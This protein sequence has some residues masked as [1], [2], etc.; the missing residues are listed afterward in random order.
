MEVKEEEEG[1]EAQDKQQE[2]KEQIFRRD[3]RKDGAPPASAALVLAACLSDWRAG[4][5]GLADF[6]GRDICS[7]GFA[8]LIRLFITLCDMIRLSDVGGRALQR[9]NECAEKRPIECFPHNGA[10]HV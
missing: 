1:G 5:G 4:A 2:Q 7:W 6:G 8:V 10:Y 9:R 3:S